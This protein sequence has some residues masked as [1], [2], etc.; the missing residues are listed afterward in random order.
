VESRSNPFL[1]STSTNTYLYAM[2]WQL[3]DI[4]KTITNNILPSS[5]SVY[6]IRIEIYSHSFHRR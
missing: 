2:D 5:L 1:E 3:L 6:A 4:G